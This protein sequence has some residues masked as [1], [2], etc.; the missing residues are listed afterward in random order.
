MGLSHFQQTLSILL[1]SSV[2]MRILV[3]EDTQRIAQ[4]IQKGLT[5]HG[6]SVDIALDGQQGYDL[7]AT[8]PY[9]VIILDL[10]LPSMDGL[11]ICRELRAE[12]ITTPILMLTAKGEVDDR[13]AG[14]TIGADDYLPKPFAFEE[15]VA[16]V[17]ALARRPQQLMGAILKYQD[18]ELDTAK[19]SVTR[20]GTSISLT[21]RE[22]ALLAYL[23]QNK[24]TVLSKEQLLSHVWEFDADVLPN[25]AEVYLGYLRSKLEKP[26]PQLPTLIYTVRG[27]GYSL[28]KA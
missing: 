10:M 6:Y 26:F 15:L 21:K 22:F 2:T 14:L 12:N 9:S 1:Y 8:E 27:F 13:V 11:T 17:K 28:G 20:A 5:A 25:T 3:I 16:R 7:A 18:V 24:E 4:A 23:L 19:A